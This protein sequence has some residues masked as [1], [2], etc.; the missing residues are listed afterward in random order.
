MDTWLIVP[1]LTN[2]YHVNNKSSCVSFV[3]DGLVGTSA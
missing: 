3:K 1:G 2:G